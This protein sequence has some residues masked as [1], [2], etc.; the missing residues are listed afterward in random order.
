MTVRHRAS[1]DSLRPEIA[2]SWLRSRLSGVSPTSP[3]K[4]ACADEIHPGRLAAAAERVL[5]SLADDLSDTGAA[6]VLADGD[7]RIFTTQAGNP[8]VQTWLEDLGAVRGARFGEDNA[9]TNAIGTPLEIRRCISVLGEE[10][11]HETFKDFSCHGEPI[12]HPSTQRTIGVLNV[13][14]HRETDNP[15]FRSL[16]RRVAHDIMTELA[17][18]SPRKEQ[19]LAAAFAGQRFRSVPARIA[20]GENSVL[21]T[22]AALDLLDSSDHVGLRALADDVLRGMTGT[23]VITLASGASVEVQWTV[24]ERAGVVAT[25]APLDAE[26]VDPSS[27]ETAE[28]DMW[29]VLVQGEHGSGRTRRALEILRHGD[30]LV[31]DGIDSGRTDLF[32]SRLDAAFRQPHTRAILIENVH[33]LEELQVIRLAQNLKRGTHRVVMTCVPGPRWEQTKGAIFSTIGRCEPVPALRTRRGDIPQIA[34]QMLQESSRDDSRRFDPAA[35][36]A[37][38][39]QQ[40]PGNLAE[41][42]RVVE[43]ASGRTR[44]GV[45]T[46]DDLPEAYRQ[47]DRPLSPR[48]DAERLAIVNALKASDNNR[49]KAATLLEI[50][51]STLYN[52]MRSLGID[53]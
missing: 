34:A 24:I 43:Y 45:L 52:R 33:L 22:P 36:R 20:L 48:E 19:A 39:S 53:R 38:A 16:A 47:A 50:S 23:R 32:D 49:S 25:L 10:H 35:L 44:A 29:P 46:A 42:R 21:A 15:L 2:S 1:A 5:H 12:H 30:H 4:V 40:W 27:G 9:G 17:V 8:S 37:L 31:L 28:L 11:F 14:F 13:C 6:L 18:Y 7:A 3:P 41:L 51:R 26:H